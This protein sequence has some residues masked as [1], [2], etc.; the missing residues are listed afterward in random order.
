MKY[1]KENNIPTV[2]TLHSKYYEDFL[3]ATHHRPLATFL[4]RRVM[5]FYQRTDQLMTVSETTKKT[6]QTYGFSKPIEVFY[7]GTHFQ[8]W[9]VSAMELNALKREL[10]IDQQVVLLF[11]GQLIWQKNFKVILDSLAILNRRR[12]PFK[13]VVVGHGRNRRDILAYHR[14][15]NLTQVVSFVGRID[16]NRT[17]SKYYQLADVMLFPSLYDNDPMVIK[18]AAVHGLPSIVATFSN[19]SEKIRHQDNGFILPATP[20]EIASGIE[21]IFK[22]PKLLKEVGVQAQKTLATS[23]EETLG[24]LISVYRKVIER[25]YDEE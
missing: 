8:K 25:F 10:G 23:W 20:E 21:A 13:M 11:V 17:L 9:D 4:N 14:H 16:D 12:F 24:G 1:A 3:Q 15:L 6:M 7:N 5:Q 19:A 2:G 18:E 22:H